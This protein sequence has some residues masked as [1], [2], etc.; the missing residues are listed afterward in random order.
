[1]LLRLR[2]LEPTDIPYLYQWENDAAVWADGA[3]HNP[4]SSQDLRDYVEQTTGDIYKDGQLRLIIELRAKE[5]SEHSESSWC[6]IGC[7]DLFDLDARNRRAAIGLYIAPAFRGK[8]Y[9]EEALRQLEEYA[10]GF[11][12]LRVLY[13]VTAVGNEACNRLFDRA[14][15]D[16][17]TRLRNWT[18]EGDAVIRVK[19]GFSSD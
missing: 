9:A 11:L 13:A 3:N 7:A 4:L 1:M 19:A 8:G 6:T 16:I 2:K 14:G 10:F 17:S 12:H 5:C 15:Y 18:L